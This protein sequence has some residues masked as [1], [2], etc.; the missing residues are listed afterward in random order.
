M[1]NTTIIIFLFSFTLLSCSKDNGCIDENKI[2]LGPCTLQ[3]EPVCGCEGKLM[4]T[5]V[6]QKMQALHLGEKGS[7]IKK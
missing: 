6:Q 3:Y 7:V 4:A 1:K 2:N 5:H